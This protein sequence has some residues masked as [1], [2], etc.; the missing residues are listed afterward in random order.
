MKNYIKTL[1]HTIKT[2]SPAE[3]KIAQKQVAKFW[4]DFYIPH[5]K[6]GCAA[7]SAFLEE[8][9]TF[10]QIKD[11][12]HQCYFIH[13][14]KWPLMS[15]GEENFET[16]ADFLLPIIEHPDGKIRQAAIHAIEYLISDIRVDLHF[17]RDRVDNQNLKKAEFIKIV[18]KNQAR[19]GNF[20]MEIEAL[21]D[22]YCEPRF[23]KYK[24]VSSLPPG[25]YK[26]LNKLITEVLLRNEHYVK[27]YQDFLNE[28]RARRHRPST[29][30]KILAKREQIK[31]Q[32]AF[33]LKNL[34]SNVNVEDIKQI[35]FNEHGRDDLGKLMRI[36]DR[37]Q[38]IDEM[39]RL[40]QIAMDAWNHFPHQRLDGASPTEKYQELYGPPDPNQ[41]TMPRLIGEI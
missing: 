19:F 16:W 17:D 6:E 27:L 28:L 30:P 18:K 12:A 14:L 40:L 2:A 38:D 13:T 37:G 33:E 11:V 4:Y 26:S 41:C 7:L 20:V 29:S 15:T 23:K 21:T 39:N 5:R 31:K 25:P 10:P 9:A 8:L 32:L 3:V 36:F 24:F 34:K 35:I 22:H 1:I